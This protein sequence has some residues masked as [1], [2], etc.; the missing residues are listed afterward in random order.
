MSALFIS[1]A[2]LSVNSAV[3]EP[4]EKKKSGEES[5]GIEIVPSSA[6]DAV[7]IKLY[8]VPATV[9]LNSSLEPVPNESPV[10]EPDV[11]TTEPLA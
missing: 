4:V 6:L 9:S 7:A 2:K 10:V 3:L 8:W 5:V 11:K 1:L